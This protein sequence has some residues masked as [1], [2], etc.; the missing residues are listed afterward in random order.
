MVFRFRFKPVNHID[1]NVISITTINNFEK[2]KMRIIFGISAL[3]IKA[4]DV[5]SHSGI[6]DIDGN[7]E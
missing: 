7:C 2:V 1:H 6:Y 4:V 5:N 3:A